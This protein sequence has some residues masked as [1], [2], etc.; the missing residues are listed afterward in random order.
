MCV[1]SALNAVDWGCLVV[2]RWM[3]RARHPV[4]SHLVG[5]LATDQ[6]GLS[7]SFGLGW[8]GQETRIIL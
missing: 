4:T 8:K 1:E 7:F 6:L 3:L 2:A 5:S